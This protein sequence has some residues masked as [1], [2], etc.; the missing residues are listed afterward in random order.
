M[1]EAPDSSTSL[2]T[3]YV[4]L[5]N[6]GTVVYR[7]TGGLLVGPNV[8]QILPTE[9]YEESGEIWEFPPGSIVECVVEF[10]EGKN[11]LIAR[12]TVKPG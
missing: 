7:P 5:L 10:R 2:Y 1:S 8:Y 4:S 6:E 9:H 11:V 3:I 12:R